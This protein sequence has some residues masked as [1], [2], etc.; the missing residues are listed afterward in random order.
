M[1]GY[2]VGAAT[3]RGSSSPCPRAAYAVCSQTE[4]I[5]PAGR[6]SSVTLRKMPG[7]HHWS[8]SSR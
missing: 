5:E 2:A 3:S 6:A 8:W 1:I 7:S 4:S